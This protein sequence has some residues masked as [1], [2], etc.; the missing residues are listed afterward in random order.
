MRGFLTRYTLAS[1]VRA[2][3]RDGENVSVFSGFAGVEGMADGARKRGERNGTPAD[4]AA[5][6]TRLRRLGERLDRA[7]AGRAA[8]NGPGAGSVSDVSGLA[9]GL[10]LSAE[11]VG[12]VIVGAGIGLGFDYLLGTSPWGFIVL[13]MLGFA[14]G[15]LT[16]M[17]S[18]G[19]IPERRL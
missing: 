10:R 5:L 9:R 18:A 16:V 3:F 12:G 19:V 4:E 17:R 6:S 14:G 8:K 2:A 13:V 7:R 15:V 1:M 11:L